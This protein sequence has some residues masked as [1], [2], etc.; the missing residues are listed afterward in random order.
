MGSKGQGVIYTLACVLV[1]I[2]ITVIGIEIAKRAG[3]NEEGTK[4]FLLHDLKEYCYTLEAV[5][6][7]VDIEYSRHVEDYA[8]SLDSSR[9]TIANKVPPLALRETEVNTIGKTAQSFSSSSLFFD[10]RGARC[11]FTTEKMEEDKLRFS[12]VTFVPETRGGKIDSL[13]STLKTL[14]SANARDEGQAMNTDLIVKFERKVGPLIVSSHTSDHV[15]ATHLARRLSAV[16]I[17]L[18]TI[19]PYAAGKKFIQIDYPFGSE[20]LLVAI[21]PEVIRIE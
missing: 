12:S 2:L 6:G 8:F 16:Y 14:F 3:E 4:L 10:N 7:V 9:L 13:T 17:Q 20:Q 15:L 18:D 21:F 11:S 1:F 19:P 5:P